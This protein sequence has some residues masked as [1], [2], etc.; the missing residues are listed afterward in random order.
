MPFY[1]SYKNEKLQIFQQELYDT[2]VENHCSAEEAIG[3]LEKKYGKLNTNEY[4]KI[5]DSHLITSTYLINNIEC[6]FKVW[7]NR[8]WNTFFDFDDF[9]EFILPYRINNEPLVEWREKYYNTFNPILDSL[10]T[11]KRDPLEAAQILF[12]TISSKEWAYY[13]YKPH[14]YVYADA[15]CLL[16]KPVGDCSEFANY[17]V[18]ISRA[19][20]IPGGIDYYLQHPYNLP[21][22]YWNF[23]FDTLGNTWEYS[24]NSTSPRIPKK[25]KPLRGRVYRKHF[26]IQEKSLPIVTR[27]EKQLPYL[28]NN[29][30][31]KDVSEHYF[32]S[33]SIVIDCKLDALQDS[34]LYLCT[35]GSNGW[36]PIAWTIYN[37]NKFTFEYVEKNLL[38]LPAYYIGGQVLPITNP[39]VVNNNNK[40]TSIQINNYSKQNLCV[41]R[42]YPLNPSFKRYQKR[43]IGGKFQASDNPLFKNAVTFATITTEADMNWH[44]IKIP[45]QRKYRY[46]RYLS[47][48]KGH[49]NMA[50]IKLIDS[51][52]KLLSGEI[53]GTSGSYKNKVDNKKEAVFDGDPLTFYDA[54][55]GDGTWAGIDFGKKVQVNEIRYIFRN[56][57]NNIRL[58][59]TYELF[60]WN[61]MQWASMGRR[62]A[63][64][65]MLNFSEIPK[66]TL[67]WLKN[68]TRGREERPFFY[69]DG[70]QVFMGT[71]E[72][73]RIFD[74]I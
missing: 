17:A 43:I 68:H 59:D 52:G 42:K 7:E 16:D 5:H 20:G 72:A 35:F 37:D 36:V 24:V 27:L 48:P 71:Q 39:G 66:G 73:E 53:I 13:W 69:I 31:V 29:L 58:G 19:L 55:E 15:L 49:C 47:A 32:H 67:L 46:F 51:E 14:L 45:T 11:N 34:I 33:D 23:V 62:K 44:S 26:G 3:I 21:G 1:Y 9:C 64:E 65:S 30:F 56:D 22:H 60:Y 38:Y 61:G 4:E 63:E 74:N 57:D 41:N 25:E 70:Q 8:E 12:D 18:Y 6:A 10:L 28:L 40:F 2:T 50:E 54:I